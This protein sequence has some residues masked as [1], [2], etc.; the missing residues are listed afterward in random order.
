MIF[1]KRLGVVGKTVRHQSSSEGV[2]G[3]KLVGNFLFSMKEEVD[4]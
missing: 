2:Q 1:W 4:S 3:W